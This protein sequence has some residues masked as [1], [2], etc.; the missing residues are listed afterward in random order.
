MQDLLFL[1]LLSRYAWW[2]LALAYQNMQ[3]FFRSLYSVHL[4]SYTLIVP[5]KICQKSG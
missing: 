3:G 1:L 2:F 4:K 5:G